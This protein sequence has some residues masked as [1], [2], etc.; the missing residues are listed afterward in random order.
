MSNYVKN[1]SLKYVIYAR[2]STESADKQ[3]QSIGDQLKLAK[4][5]AANERLKVVA[6]FSESK[7]AGTP[8]RREEFNKMIELIK[9]GK[10]NAI[11]TWKTDRLSRNPLESGMIQQ[12]VSDGMIKSILLTSGGNYT[13][14]DEL[15][16]GVEASMNSIFLKNLSKNVTRG[17][18]TK[19]ESGWYPSVAPIGYL[20]DRLA[21]TI[22][23]DEERFHKVRL[24]WDKYLEGNMTVAELSRYADK[25]LHIRTVQRSKTGGN[26]LTYNGVRKMLENP[27]YYGKFMR[28]GILYNGNHEP[29]ITEEE[30][31]RVQELLGN[32]N[33]NTRPKSELYPFVFRGMLTCAKCGFAVV[34][35]RKTKKYKNGDEGVFTYCHCSGKCKKFKCP[36]RKIYVRED[37]LMKQ[38]QE[39]LAKYT[40]DEEF[41][42]LAIEALAEEED[43]EISQRDA[44][45]EELNKLLETKN[46]HYD[47]LRRMRYQGQIDDEW[48]DKESIELETQITDIR[49]QL[50]SVHNAAKEW[51][52]IANSVF[53]FARQA[54]ELFDKGTLEDKQYV[55]RTLGVNLKL[56]GRTIQFTPNK[57]LV[58]IQKTASALNKRLAAGITS[59]LK[60]SDTEKASL[61]SNWYTGRDS[62]PRPLVPKTSALIH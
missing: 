16:M 24:L 36:Q 54:K 60:R 39:E 41:Y 17:M 51:R 4:E 21:K 5:K 57:Y 61:I 29:M 40:I 46:K 31:I 38:V 26:P 7:S 19:A 35:E 58:P 8:G 56:S 9:N 45:T 62:N 30:F 47:N 28:N 25:T 53:L 11:L 6:T 13:A 15:L 43:I 3:V 48:Y 42:N 18:R 59:D 1:E 52:G 2:K 23:K 34:T 32:I 49:R 20:N 22:I 44:K 10:A 12:M 50:D 33:H 27:F 14:E 55:L 37:E